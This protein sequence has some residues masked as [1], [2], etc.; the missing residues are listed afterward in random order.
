[1][2]CG[3]KVVVKTE[4]KYIGPPFL[5]YAELE[6]PEVA[7][8]KTEHLYQLLYDYE[9]RLGLCLGDREQIRLWAERYLK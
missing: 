2:G 4:T 5:Y 6:A 1:M 8:A 7:G 3:G 9:Q